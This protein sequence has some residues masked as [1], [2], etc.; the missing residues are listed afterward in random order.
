MVPGESEAAAHP[1]QQGLR[2]YRVIPVPA[3]LR[4]AEFAVWE[5]EGGLG[6]EQEAERLK[7]WVL[8]R[9]TLIQP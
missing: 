4:T 1:H 8:Q 3:Q 7:E 5:A 9:Q 2:A 6:R